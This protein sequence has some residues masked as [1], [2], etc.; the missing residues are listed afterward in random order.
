MY[1]L[2]PLPSEKLGRPKKRGKRIHMNDFTLSW[3][4]AGM[5]VGHRIVLTHIC[6]NRRIHAYVSCTTSGSRRLFFSTLNPSDL[7]ISCAWQERKILRDAPA[8]GMDYYPLKLYKLR[9]AIETNYYEQKAFWSLNAYRIRR[10]NGIEHMVNLVNLV[11]S[12]LK[13]LPYLDEHFAKYQN[14]SPQELRSH[15]SWQI[16][17]EIF[18]GTLVSKAQSAKNPTDLV[19]ALCKLVLSTSEAA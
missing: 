6:G 15:I 4:M 5:Q 7:H 12:S 17:R 11:H 9:W 13:M 10:Q 16:Q 2:P 3:N 14:T 8:E 19:Q 1:E 18:L